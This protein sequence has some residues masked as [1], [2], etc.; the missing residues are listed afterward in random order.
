MTMI[1]AVF[2]EMETILSSVDTESTLLMLVEDSVLLQTTVM[3]PSSYV[4][5]TAVQLS[6][7]Q[8]Q[9]P[10]STNVDF[11]PEYHTAALEQ[12]MLSQ[13]NGDYK[14][15]TS[16]NTVRINE[17]SVTFWL[18]GGETKEGRITLQE[19]QNKYTVVLTSDFNP[20]YFWYWTDGG[21]D[22]LEWTHYQDFGCKNSV[23]WTKI[24]FNTQ[25]QE[26]PRRHSDVN[27]TRNRK[28]SYSSM[29]SRK[30]SYSSMH[31]RKNSYSSMHSSVTSDCLDISEGS[32]SMSPQE[33]TPSNCPFCPEGSP[34]FEILVS[35]KKNIANAQDHN[36]K[37]KMLCKTG[38]ECID[39]WADIIIDEER[40]L[41]LRETIKEERECQDVKA[42]LHNICDDK[43]G[44]RG[45]FVFGIRAK[46][47]SELENTVLFLKDMENISTF[48][49]MSLIFNSKRKKVDGIS[50][51]KR[52][53]KTL[54]IYVEVEDVTQIQ[55][56]LQRYEEKWS[57]LI[58][59]C[60]I[61][62]DEN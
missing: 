14:I 56:V 36:A 45:P 12:E 40:A 23:R 54:C 7:P 20:E 17:G 57:H 18:D 62:D 11:S 26:T 35:P 58:S 15:T 61:R 6:Y 13:F 51:K 43:P 46:K 55:E 10:S 60:Q 49:R 39:I 59:Y 22:F 34:P 32:Y 37:Q 33:R 19:F 29:H 16:N 1:S 27:N 41:N 31:S 47:L 28:N 9:L 25:W 2:T 8:N 21:D 3:Q 4:Q 50:L 30:N 5:A 44:L 48:K 24:N 38:F 42:I 52:Q 53:K